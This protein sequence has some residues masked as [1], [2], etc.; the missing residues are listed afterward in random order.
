[1][2]WA[3]TADGKLGASWIGSQTKA[4]EPVN[5]QLRGG[6]TVLHVRNEN[7]EPISGA[8]VSVYMS[9]IDDMA[10]IVPPNIRLLLTTTTDK[11][12]IVRFS[13]RLGDHELGFDVRAPGHRPLARDFYSGL[14][15]KRVKL[16]VLSVDQD[17]TVACSRQFLKE[18]LP[19]SKDTWLINAGRP[20]HF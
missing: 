2:I 18:K 7:C 8:T 15:P 20:D 10:E 19:N 1:M 9:G 13:S 5:I 17:A 4:S 16:F 3:A 6:E 14:Q 11:N 12:G